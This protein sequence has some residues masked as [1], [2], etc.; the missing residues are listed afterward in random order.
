[1]GKKRV[2]LFEEPYKGKAMFKMYFIVA[3]NEKSS[4][5]SVVETETNLDPKNFR[6]S[7]IKYEDLHDIDGD[8]VL[9]FSPAKAKEVCDEITHLVT[10]LKPNASVVFSVKSEIFDSDI[11]AKVRQKNHYF[12]SENA[13]DD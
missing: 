10:S 4:Q 3:T 6:V 1:M 9:F 5:V 8:P 12:S 7:A 2:K 13:S 11:I